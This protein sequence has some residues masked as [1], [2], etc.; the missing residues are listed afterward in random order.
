M[1]SDLIFNITATCK[2]CEAQ[3]TVSFDQTADKVRGDRLALWDCL[4]S[5]WSIEYLSDTTILL[6]PSCQDELRKLNALVAAFWED[7][8]SKI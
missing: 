6:C 4:P 1:P 3:E 2:K 5:G 8:K 7:I